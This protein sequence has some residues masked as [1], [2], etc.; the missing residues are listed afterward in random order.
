MLVGISASSL[1]HLAL[2]ALAQILLA[3]ARECTPQL[4]EMR[5]LQPMFAMIN[6]GHSA[7]M[8]LLR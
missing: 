6:R 4:V 8:V 1:A 5:G 2:Q 7:L 3:P